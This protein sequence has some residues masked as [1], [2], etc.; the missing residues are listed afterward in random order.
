MSGSSE[1]LLLFFPTHYLYDITT[2]TGCSVS[3]PPRIFLVVSVRTAATADP[4]KT[5]AERWTDVCLQSGGK[6]D[7]WAAHL[8]PAHLTLVLD[9]G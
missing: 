2:V 5:A 4:P 7:L 1:C 9:S 6:G 3:S 8:M